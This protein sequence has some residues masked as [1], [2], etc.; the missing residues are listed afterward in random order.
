MKTINIKPTLTDKQKQAMRL[1]FDYDN[2]VSEVVYGGAAGGGKSYIG[3]L[4]IILGCLK[5][6]GTRWLIGRSKLNTLKQTTLKTFFEVCKNLNIKQGE[7][8]K[9]NQQTNQITFLNDS[10]IILKDL[11][12]YP[13]DPDFDSLGSLEIAGAF[14]DEANQ[15]SEKA[16]N[17][18]SS[19]IR[20]KLDA[21]GIS[22]KIFMSCNP[23][24]GWIYN[25]FY[26]KLNDNK[27]ESYKA[28]IPAL[29]E[30][31]EFISKHYVSNL[32]KMD[33]ISKNRLLYGIWEYSDSLSLFDYDAI[34]DM[35]ADEDEQPPINP[36]ESN[37]FS[38]DVARL[39]KDKTCILVWNGLNIIEIKELSKL[40]FDIQRDE[41]EKIRTKYNVSIKNMCFDT[42]GVGGGLADMFKG[43]VYI[44]NNGKAV[45]DDN[46]Q[47]IKTQMYFKLADLINKGE[48]RVY[49]FNDDQ[50]TRLTQEL[51]VIKR[52]NIDQDGKIKMTNK[53]SLKKV[54]GRSP[55]ISDAMAY[56]MHFI[57]KPKSKM[58]FAFR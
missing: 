50:K 35:F 14:I 39:G 48:L 33:T 30:D 1:L 52:E 45:N 27:L 49:G 17:M 51:Q 4:F 43:S 22:P 25:E 55:D 44:V 57:L 6:P 12:S 41:I 20:H 16:K 21:F 38:I 42:D 15:V 19:R 29:V 28:F 34:V 26:K 7:H 13:S 24:K 53:E 47:N 2:G 32:E 23:N 9:Y 46:Y 5:Y 3:C 54:I 58:G 56:R 11:F 36:N 37:Y 31:N 40:T 18:V 8:F 10:E